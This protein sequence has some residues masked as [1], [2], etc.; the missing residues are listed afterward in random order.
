MVEI[1]QVA[2]G[3]SLRGKGERQRYGRR[4]V[5]CNLDIRTIY[6][7]LNIA[8]G[9]FMFIA[10]FSHILFYLFTGRKGSSR[11]KVL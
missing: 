1:S 11:K 9:W 3:N 8:V 7:Q 4:E 10:T 2:K 5:L 6:F